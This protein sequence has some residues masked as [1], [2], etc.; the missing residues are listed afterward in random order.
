M[1]ASDANTF[2]GLKLPKSTFQA[3]RFIPASQQ[4]EIMNKPVR[5]ANAVCHER[6][7][8]G[9]NHWC[10]YLRVGESTSVHLDITPSYI[11]PSTT[12]AGGSKANMVVSLVGYAVSP[13]AQKVVKL[14]IPAGKTVRDLVDLLLE[15]GREK[16]EFNGQGQG[17]RYWTDHQL[18]LFCEHGLFIDHAQVQEAKAAI[19]TQWPD[20]VQY[21]LVQGGYYQ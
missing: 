4:N 3:L 6:L 19:L 7:P 15:H 11:V 10:F 13:A 1:A 17:C 20:Q 2:A 9:G 21:P 16:Y 12:I 8:Q 14:D 5:W 18:D